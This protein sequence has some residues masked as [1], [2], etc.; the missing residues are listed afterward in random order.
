M[1]GVWEIL[2]FRFGIIRFEESRMDWTAQ[3]VDSGKRILLVRTRQGTPM[4]LKM[5]KNQVAAGW[6]DG[7][8]E[9]ELLDY[10][11][12]TFRVWFLRQEWNGYSKE[13]NIQG[14]LGGTFDPVCEIEAKRSGDDEEA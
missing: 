14:R 13:A 10:Q 4:K 8:S 5:S 11:G 2:Q 3:N 1:V 12:T 9:Y 7:R 6:N